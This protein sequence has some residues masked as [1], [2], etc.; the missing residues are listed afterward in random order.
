LI[1]INFL[2]S[3]KNFTFNFYFKRALSLVLITFVIFI[4][5]N[6]QRLNDEIK[7]YNFDPLVNSNFIFTEDKDFY[8]R[9]NI[10]IKENRKNFKMMN[11]G[12][13]NFLI[14]INK[15]D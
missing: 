6:Y 10:Y 5:R 3:S 4:F 14:T 11:F 12:G 2:I 9:Y 1:P 8:F 13:K 15:H 7:K